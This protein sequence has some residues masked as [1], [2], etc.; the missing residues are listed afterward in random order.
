[1]EKWSKNKR[2]HAENE[3]EREKMEEF[4][5]PIRRMYILVHT[6]Y[7]LD[8]RFQPE[9]RFSYT[10]YVHLLTYGLSII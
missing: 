10:L 9:S 2:K 1:M 6:A 8:D 4:R 7:P 5:R 3:E